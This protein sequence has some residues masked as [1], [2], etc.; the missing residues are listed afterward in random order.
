MKEKLAIKSNLEL[1]L[2]FNTF[3]LMDNSQNT[4]TMNNYLWVVLY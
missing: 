2:S 3:F 4:N 1:L